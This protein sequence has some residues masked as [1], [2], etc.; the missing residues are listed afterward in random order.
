MCP[1]S[2]TLQEYLHN[3]YESLLEV[4]WPESKII[5]YLAAVRVGAMLILVEARKFKHWKTEAGHNITASELLNYIG[6][7]AE[8]VERKDGNQ[9]RGVRRY[10][11]RAQ[12]DY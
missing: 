1:G 5:D 12:G 2:E 3:E 8:K 6:F 9:S 10:R 7:F 4:G 11:R